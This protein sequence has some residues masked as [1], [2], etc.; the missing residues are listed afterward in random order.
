MAQSKGL[1][2]PRIHLYGLLL[3]GI[4]EA[5]ILKKPKEQWRAEWEEEQRTQPAA[6]A[7]EA[8]QAVMKNMTALGKRLWFQKYVPWMDHPEK[9]AACEIL[10]G[11][12][13]WDAI[14]L[15]AAEEEEEAAE[16]R[17]FGPDSQSGEKRFYPKGEQTRDPQDGQSHNFRQ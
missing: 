6:S 12:Q 17:T 1:A 15:A 13:D 2:L 16:A 5:A 4:P 14:R 3:W 10:Y 7:Q 9:R 8:C 11:P